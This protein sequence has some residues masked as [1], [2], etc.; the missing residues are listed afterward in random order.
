MNKKYISLI[1]IITLIGSALLT[2]CGKNEEESTVEDEM[3]MAILKEFTDI[4]AVPRNN[5][6]DMSKV[7]K[8]ITDRA[9]A[10]GLKSKT[11]KA[12]N[13][14]IEKPASAGY[15]NAP[16]TVLQSNMDMVVKSS[17][18]IIFDP[19]KDGITPMIND[20]TGKI[21]G[22]HTSLGASSGL[23]MATMFYV[24]GSTAE[25]G[26]VK[27]IFTVDG[28][29]NMTGAKNID[30]EFLKGEYL[31]NLNNNNTENIETGSA[32][33]SVLSCVEK[34]EKNDTRNKYSFVLAA[35]G[36]V[37]GDSGVGAQKNQGNPI[38]FLA[39]VMALTKSEGLTFELNDIESGDKATEIPKCAKAVITLNEYEKNKINT[40]FN[41]AKKA[42]LKEHSESD[43][44]AKLEILET[45]VPDKALADKDVDSLI[46]FLYSIVDGKYNDNDKVT[47]SSNVGSVNVTDTEIVC[48][49]FAQSK[50]ESAL[51]KMIVDHTQI[52]KI[53]NMTLNIKDQVDG[54]NTDKKSYLPSQLS[55]I[56]KTDLKIKANMGYRTTR[57]E[58]GFFKEKSPDLEIVSIGFTDEYQGEITEYAKLDSV[59][60][61]ACT[62]LK[63]L[64][65][66]ST[67]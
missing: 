11:D 61:P 22:N 60:I 25:Q 16:V 66:L 67:R 45:T 56:Y 18:S 62:I 2:S 42:Y 47:A 32:Y 46:S 29:G 54:Y 38:M 27:A 10:L 21:T 5:G 48:E 33:S 41:K 23:G 7:S 28:E 65:G 4:S 20:D 37:G 52:A 63:F 14:M 50:L 12:G 13:I 44:N 3:Q 8:Y 6:D 1:L 53:S 51:D 58:L 35:D 24:L 57:T 26:K 9:K 39:E 40:I 31:I 15:E 49:I 43:P 17:P 34:V 55:E 36:F 64:N 19:T 30:A 59:D